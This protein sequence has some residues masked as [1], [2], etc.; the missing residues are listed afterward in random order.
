M[1][2]VFEWYLESSEGRQMTQT[3]KLAE[4]FEDNEDKFKDILQDSER[5]S[6]L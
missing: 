6:Q 4:K 1:K 5:L 3:F 2:K